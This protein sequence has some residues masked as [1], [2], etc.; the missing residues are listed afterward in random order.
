VSN[1][2]VFVR[3][4]EQRVVVDIIVSKNTYERTHDICWSE[5]V[6]STYERGDVARVPATARSTTSELTRQFAIVDQPAGDV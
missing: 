2:H 4:V 1:L 6:G 5:G 3:N